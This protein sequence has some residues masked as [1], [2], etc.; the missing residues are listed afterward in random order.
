M[1]TICA[2]SEGKR[3]STT[4]E[5][6]EERK[7]TKGCKRMRSEGRQIGAIRMCWIVLKNKRRAS[8]EVLK[9]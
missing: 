2:G 1:K 4:L 5:L 6:V 8:S 7:Y 3:E 9:P